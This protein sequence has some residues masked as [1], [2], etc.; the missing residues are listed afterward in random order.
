MS[1][2]AHSGHFC[3]CVPGPT[4]CVAA[5]PHIWR[6]I[7]SNCDSFNEFGPFT[8]LIHIHCFLFWGQLTEWWQHA[9]RQLWLTSEI[10]ITPK[11]KRGTK[12]V[13][14][15]ILALILSI[16]VALFSY[17]SPF[18]F[19]YL[20]DKDDKMNSKTCIY[21]VQGEKGKKGSNKLCVRVSKIPH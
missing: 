13:V 2:Q 6:L 15:I 18:F 5:S 17:E 12:A 21:W 1:R 7:L 11:K 20:W 4:S 16:Q 3:R 8:A 10:I 14:Y 19:I 9:G